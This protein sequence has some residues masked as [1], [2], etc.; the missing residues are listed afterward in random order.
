MIAEN[1]V[2]LGE[3]HPETS[4]GQGTKVW[5]G[6]TVREGAVIGRQVVVGE[7]AYIDYGVHIGDKCKIQNN[8]L[9]YNPSTIED[10]VFI[11]PG[12]ILTN[13]KV[14]RSTAPNG[15]VS[16]ESDWKRVAVHCRRGSS[17]GAGAVC[18]GP[19]EIGEWSMV[20]A[21]SV[22]TRDVSAYSLVAGNPAKHLHWIGRTGTKLVW[23]RQLWQCADTGELFREI[24]GGLELV[25]R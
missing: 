19:V 9:I 25:Q 14:P 16:G 24:E 18:I 8:A 10:G 3:I 5:R 22:V 7:S 20:G 17:I 11:G 15:E 13:D 21:G 2:R 12:V 4:I 6:A 23:K 1:E